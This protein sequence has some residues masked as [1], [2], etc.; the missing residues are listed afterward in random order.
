MGVA[1]H[2][3]VSGTLLRVL[4]RVRSQPWHAV[5]PVATSIEEEFLLPSLQ[6]RFML[7][8]LVLGCPRLARLRV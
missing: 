7:D 2:A 1:P 4:A 3:V 5:C 8:L 6:S